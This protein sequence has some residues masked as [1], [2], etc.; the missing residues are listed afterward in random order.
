[1]LYGMIFFEL[2]R[3]GWLLISLLLGL[4]E[5][6]MLMW[7]FRISNRYAIPIMILANATSIYLIYFTYTFYYGQI[8]NPHLNDEF[9]ARHLHGSAANTTGPIPFIY[10]R[11]KVE[12]ALLYG[13]FFT[14]TLTQCPFL[15]FLCRRSSKSK[16][17]SVKIVLIMNLIFYPLILSFCIFIISYRMIM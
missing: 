6:G 7:K 12:N 9:L 1:M 15:Y 8:Y 11:D 2:S 17:V 16:L 14:V 5:A 4:L 13:H 3:I 10:D